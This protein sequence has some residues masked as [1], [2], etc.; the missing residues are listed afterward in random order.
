MWPVLQCILQSPEQLDRRVAGSPWHTTVSRA[1]FGSSRGGLFRAIG[2]ACGRL[3]CDVCN[4]QSSWAG[5]W[6]VLQ[7]SLQNS[8]VGVLPVSRSVPDQFVPDRAASLRVGSKAVLW[9]CNLSNGGANFF[10]MLQKFSGY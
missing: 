10:L 5:V 2:S 1:S 3:S 6:L 7:C 4:L 9:A 8:L